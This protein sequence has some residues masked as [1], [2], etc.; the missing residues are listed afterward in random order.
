MSLMVVIQNLLLTVG[1]LLI[2]V[3]T[4]YYGHV[5]LAQDKLDH[6]LHLKS[7]DKFIEFT[8]FK[9]CLYL[10][11][12]YWLLQIL[13]QLWE[14]PLLVRLSFQDAILRGDW[15]L[16]SAHYS[17]AFDFSIYG[18][19]GNSN[20]LEICVVI[21]LPVRKISAWSRKASIDHNV[22]ILCGVGVSGI[23]WLVV[24]GGRFHWH[25]YYRWGA[26]GRY[27]LWFTK[28]RQQ[29]CIRDYYYDRTA[30]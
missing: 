5:L 25:S 7:K 24:S 17:N 11:L 18:L 29:L 12:T 15:H 27:W 30:G 23:V 6:S 13:L 28:Y 14:V 20:G 4:A 3:A 10:I 21:F 8:I 2:F 26:L 1:A 19:C 22:V 9:V 16:F